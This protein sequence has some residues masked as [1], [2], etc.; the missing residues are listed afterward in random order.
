MKLDFFKMHAQGN[1][2]IY[3]D[4]LDKIQPSLD[5]SKLAQ[6]ICDRHL[7]IGGDG[8]VLILNDP[9]NDVFMRV[10]NSDGS[11]ANNCG[12]ALSC[13]SAYYYK[14][15]NIKKIIINTLSG[16]KIGEII[17]I[18]DNKNIFVRI[19][20]G[21]PEF[22]K[23]GID[24]INHFEGYQISVGNHHFVTFVD[25]LSPDIVSKF[26]PQIEKNKLF[27]YGINVEFVKRIS[28]NLIEVKVW[29]RGSGE[30][31]ACGSGA[32]AAVF[33]GIQNSLLNNNVTV[34][35]PGGNLQVEYLGKN[36]YLT[37][38]VSYIF[39]GNIEI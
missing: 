27:P 7:G 19:N 4:F 31:L 13:I 32:C 25:E 24:K 33:A 21:T 6:K 16:I 23:K 36:I 2:Y 9:E 28:S 22:L 20:L 35:V 18:K 3:F 11:E 26:G 38:N 15:F 39:G 29:E 17:N 10:F 37:G 14:K 12:S 8:I 34:K 30:T 5:F 1:D